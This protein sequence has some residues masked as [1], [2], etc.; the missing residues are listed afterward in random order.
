MLRILLLRISQMS[1]DAGGE[2]LL[3]HRGASQAS[4]A[5]VEAQG[6]SREAAMVIEIAQ[7]EIKPGSEKDFEAAVA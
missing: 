7:I 5:P 6:S 2:L 1:A 4:V 3:R